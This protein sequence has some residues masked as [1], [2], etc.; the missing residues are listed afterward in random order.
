M[1]LRRADAAEVLADAAARQ[2][3]EAWQQ[4]RSADVAAERARAELSRVRAAVRSLC[5]N[6]DTTSG[7]GRARAFVEDVRAVL[8]AGG[9]R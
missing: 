5:D 7:S 3:D 4:R 6:F 9:R 2:R 1:D 8:D